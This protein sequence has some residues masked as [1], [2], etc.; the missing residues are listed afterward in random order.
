MDSNWRF[1]QNYTECVKLLDFLRYYIVLPI[2]HFFDFWPKLRS[3]A[4]MFWQ[5]FRV[6]TKFSIYLLSKLL[7]LFNFWS[8]VLFVTRI[9]I[10]ESNFWSSHFNIELVSTCCKKQDPKFISRSYGPLVQLYYV[11]N[12]LAI[13]KC[14]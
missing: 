4:W 5:N 14:R 8:N 2:E 11:L 10:F 6:F 9:S 1:Q 3:L 12:L 7:K 13:I